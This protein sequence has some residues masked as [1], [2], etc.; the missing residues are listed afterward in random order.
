MRTPDKNEEDCDQGPSDQG[1]C[2]GSEDY[3]RQIHK[4]YEEQEVTI[5][6]NCEDV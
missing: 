2:Q 3:H 4:G 6:R 1:G 5:K